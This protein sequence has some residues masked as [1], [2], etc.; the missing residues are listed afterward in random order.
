MRLELRLW[1]NSGFPRTDKHCWKDGRR[2][3]VVIRVDNSPSVLLDGGP[4]PTRQCFS[5]ACLLLLLPL[6]YRNTVYN[7]SFIDC[8]SSGAPVHLTA[9]P[10]GQKHDGAVSVHADG[11]HMATRGA[12]VGLRRLRQML[13]I[14]QQ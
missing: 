4:P 13:R 7:F 2:S 11:G 12:N 8:P 10:T 9:S 6:R 1:V 3:P 14:L 5:A